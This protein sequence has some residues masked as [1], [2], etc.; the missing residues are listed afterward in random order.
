MYKNVLQ[1]IEGIG[2]YPLISMLIFQAVFLVVMIWFFRADKNY[3][4]RMAQLPLEI[5]RQ[6]NDHDEE[7]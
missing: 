6:Q 7:A 3:L 4:Q 1:T 5:N 2:I